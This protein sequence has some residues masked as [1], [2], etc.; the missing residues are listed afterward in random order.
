MQRWNITKTWYNSLRV[1]DI[2]G[3][4]IQSIDLYEKDNV[5]WHWHMGC[6]MKMTTDA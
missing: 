5:K 2:S 1:Y 4:E 6:S 3:T